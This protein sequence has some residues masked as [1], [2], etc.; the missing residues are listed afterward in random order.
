MEAEI[1]DTL[2]EIRDSI[3]E[4]GA[5]IGGKLDLHSK[6]FQQHLIEDTKNFTILEL[7]QKQLREEVMSIERRRSESSVRR[8][9]QAAEESKNQKAD[10][11]AAIAGR[12]AIY[13]ALAG[14]TALW[15]MEH[16]LTKK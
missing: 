11:L 14:S 8:A 10:S 5:E 13:A 7:G 15:I 4:S 1:K 12:Y 9:T 3:K 16:F 2:K 6:Q